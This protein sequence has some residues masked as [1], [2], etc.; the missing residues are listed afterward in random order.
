MTGSYVDLGDSVDNALDNGVKDPKI[1]RR[2]GRALCNQ[3]L[4]DYVDLES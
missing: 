3:S 2:G 1:V 4:N